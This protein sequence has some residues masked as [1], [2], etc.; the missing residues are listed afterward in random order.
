[1]PGTTSILLTG[2]STGYTSKVPDFLYPAS[3]T[4]SPPAFPDS[5]TEHVTFTTPSGLVATCGGRDGPRSGSPS[6]STCLVLQA[7]KWQS[8]PRVPDLPAGRWGAT[9]ASV[10]AGVIVMG[11]RENDDRRNLV[12]STSFVL[13]K[14]G[15]FWEEGP[16][17]PGDGAEYS[18]S[19]AVGELVFLLGGVREGE[20]S[21]VRELDTSTW[22]WQ[23]EGKWPQLGG[24]GRTM[25]GCGVL[26]S[27]LI[28]AGGQEYMG[29]VSDMTATLDLGTRGARWQEGGRLKLARYFHAMVTMGAVGQEK[30]YAL[31]GCNLGMLDSVEVWG[32][33]S[34]TWREEQERL[35][36]AKG[37]MGAVAVREASVCQ[38]IEKG[39]D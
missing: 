25:H 32:E 36:E 29:G 10:P 8:D 37:Y 21:Q 34:R 3:S 39:E 16:A 22:E 33:E 28:V 19:V 7:G 14:N 24:R 9:A 35:P 30:L 1:M 15:S 13:R 18:C 26:N 11:G 17:L 20:T 2:G 12:A 27:Q 4:C 38:Q 23:E 5:R 31:G 6:L